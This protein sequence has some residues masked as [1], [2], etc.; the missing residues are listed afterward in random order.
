MLDL[1]LQV[2]N[3]HH[4]GRPDLFRKDGQKYKQQD[5]IRILNDEKTPVFAGVDQNDNMLGYAMCIFKEAK[6]NTSLCDYKSL[7]V[8]DL[9]VDESYRGQHIGKTILDFAVNFAK[10]NGCAS[11][12]LN[13]WACNESAR[14]FYESY[15][16]KIQKIGME[17]L[18]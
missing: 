11:V 8:D 6:N 18:L 1:L 7:Y 10:E 4:E 15:G 16:M 13:V 17:K 3:V 12:T 5:L 14:S 2:C 9:C